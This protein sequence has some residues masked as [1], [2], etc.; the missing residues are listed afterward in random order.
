MYLII[1][2]IANLIFPAILEYQKFIGTA[3]KTEANMYMIRIDRYYAMQRSGS[4][5]LNKLWNDSHWHTLRIQV[6]FIG[7]QG[8]ENKRYGYSQFYFNVNTFTNVCQPDLLHPT[9]TSSPCGYL[10]MNFT[11]LK[12][13]NSRS[14]TSKFSASWMRCLNLMRLEEITAKSIA[15]HQP[16]FSSYI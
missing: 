11:A 15:D 8:E 2:S 1:K 13:Q 10:T 16:K 3:F 12:K 14:K 6:G 5:L 9:N 7:E 4:S